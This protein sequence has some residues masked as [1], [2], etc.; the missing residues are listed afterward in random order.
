MHLINRDGD[1][2]TVCQIPARTTS[3]PSLT[4]DARDALNAG[5]LRLLDVCWGCYYGAFVTLR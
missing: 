3:D 5:D 2:L 4:Q 1:D